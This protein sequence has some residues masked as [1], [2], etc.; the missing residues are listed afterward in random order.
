[1]TKPKQKLNSPKSTTK[2]TAS[3]TPSTPLLEYVTQLMLQ[4]GSTYVGIVCVSSDH[5]HISLELKTS[6]PTL[7][8]RAF[9][10]VYGVLSFYSPPTKV[11]DHVAMQQL[12]SLPISHP[13]RLMS[14]PETK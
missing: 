1:M 9:P 7:S 2:S 6:S 13:L 3:P 11:E 12:V 4:D 8:P 5:R 10:L 14:N